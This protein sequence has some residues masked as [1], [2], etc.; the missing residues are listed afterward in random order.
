MAVS[1]T[2]CLYWMNSVADCWQTSIVCNVVGQTFAV[3]TD[4]NTECVVG[5]FVENAS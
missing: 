4:C 2:A 1:G 5:E 3:S